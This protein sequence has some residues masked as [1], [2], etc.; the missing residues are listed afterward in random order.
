MTVTYL[1]VKWQ[2][3]PGLN[4]IH[5]NG[6]LP[7]HW[8]LPMYFAHMYKGDSTKTRQPAKLQPWIWY[9]IYQCHFFSLQ[10]KTI[11]PA[12]NNSYK[13]IRKMPRASPLGTVPRKTKRNETLRDKN[14]NN[15]LSERLKK[16]LVLGTG[17]LSPLHFIQTWKA[18]HHSHQTAVVPKVFVALLVDKWMKQSYKQIPRKRQTLVC[19]CLLAARKLFSC[20]VCNKIVKMHL[21]KSLEWL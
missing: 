3:W 17:K 20:W 21:T 9:K 18:V 13:K 7:I 4:P 19:R 15:L 11:T 12:Q 8:C 5:I 14:N 2:P 10:S 16:R 6:C 1:E